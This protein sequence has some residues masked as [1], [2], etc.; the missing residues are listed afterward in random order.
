MRNPFSSRS[1]E[2]VLVDLSDQSVRYLVVRPSSDSMKLLAV[3]ELASSSEQAD[4]LSLATRLREA[5]DQV[6]VKCKSAILLLSRPQIE[7]VA[8]TLPPSTNE[9]LPSLVASIVAQHSD[10]A[11]AIKLLADK[12]KYRKPK[13]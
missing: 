11:E 4:D 6:P 12:F 1:A 5:L 3:G 9:E 2:L 10:E 13:K 7:S 8:E